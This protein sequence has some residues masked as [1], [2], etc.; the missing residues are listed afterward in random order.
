ML[1]A[2][3]PAAAALLEGVLTEDAGLLGA[4]RWCLW[5]QRCWM[6]SCHQTVGPVL[7][8]YRRSTAWLFR[9][10]VASQ[11]DSLRRSVWETGAARAQMGQPLP[12]V[13]TGKVKDVLQNRESRQIG[14]R[15]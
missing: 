13:S 1:L 15:R 7:L 9:T 12:P 2:D 10:E 11:L 14:F 8:G 3:V 6:A 4:P 5:G